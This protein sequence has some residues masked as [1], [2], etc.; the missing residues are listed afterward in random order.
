[1]TQPAGPPPGA[2]QLGERIRAAG[3]ADRVVLVAGTVMVV[4]SFLPWYGAGLLSSGISG[5]S[6]E[7]WAILSILCGIAAGLL[8]LGRLAGVAD[9]GPSEPTVALA[10]GGG[11]L[12]FA[13]I[14]IITVSTLATTGLYGALAIGALLTFVGWQRQ[15]GRPDLG[16]PARAPTPPGTPRAALDSAAIVARLRG[17]VSIWSI[18]G[19]ALAGLLLYPATHSVP[20]S[21]GVSFG[22]MAMLTVL[23]ALDATLDPLWLILARI[24]KPVRWI[25]GVAIPVFLSISRF[26]PEAGGREIESAQTGV[27]LSALVA[28]VAFHGPPKQDG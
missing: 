16:L 5:W 25:A 22:M 23:R 1:M 10:L 4:D 13:L 27:F 2:A 28:Y 18:L 7:S 9:L 12:G 6:S 11:C 8:V 24:P 19:S 17:A 15:Q 26:Q 20:G 14:R 21:M 3:T